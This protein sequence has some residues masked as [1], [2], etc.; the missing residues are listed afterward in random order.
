MEFLCFVIFIIIFCVVSFLLS[1]AFHAA[2][3][4]HHR[5]DLIAKRVPFYDPPKGYVVGVLCTASGYND[6]R[7]SYDTLA[8]GIIS[9]NH[10]KISNIRSHRVTI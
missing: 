6:G 3:C 9:F 7:V 8:K 10:M 1:A 4:F 5:V 2:G